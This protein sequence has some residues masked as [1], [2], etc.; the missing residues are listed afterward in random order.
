MTDRI[1]QNPCGDSL[2]RPEAARSNESPLENLD[3]RTRPPSK[4]RE[5]RSAHRGFVCLKKNHKIQVGTRWSDRKPLAPTSPHLKIRILPH[6][7]A[8]GCAPGFLPG[9]LFPWP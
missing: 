8:P 9:A 3:F 6:G 5:V 4:F 1:S 7:F 2:E